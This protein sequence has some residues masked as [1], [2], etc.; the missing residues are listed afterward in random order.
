MPISL[1][2]LLMLAA[3]FLIAGGVGFWLLGGRE[4]KKAASA[5]EVPVVVRLAEKKDVPH[6][7]NAVGTVESLQ[8]VLVRPQVDGVLT[9]ILFKEGDLVAKD[10]LLATIDD[11]S[12]Q[13]VLAAAKA[14]LSSN[15]ALLRA[16]ELDLTRYGGL[17]KQGGVSRQTYEQ[18]RSET[19]RLRAAVEASEARIADAEVQLSYTKIH[20]PVAGRVGIRRVDSG[21]LVRANDTSGLV[22]VTQVDPISVVFTIPQ[23]ELGDL[24]EAQVNAGEE[25]VAVTALDRQSGKELSVGRITAID[26]VVLTGTGTVRVRAVFD[27]AAD[28]LWTGQFVSL[29]VPTT[30][31]RD[32][33]VVPASAVRPGIEGP[34]VYLIDNNLAKPVNVK[35]GYRNDKIAVIADGVDAGA[36]VVTDGYSRLKTDAKVK[37]EAGANDAGVNATGLTPAP[38]PAVAPAAASEPAPVLMMPDAATPANAPAAETKAVAP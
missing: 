29:R 33:I 36:V 18:Q 28:R 1:S 27:N 10:Q 35:L 20:S 17:V 24:R 15:R 4:E 21:N 30:T 37:I 22:M 32:A 5:P 23:D 19:E 26:N 12:Y 8:S 31:T 2:R 11:R 14:E 3:A 7:F 16:A 34:F 13:A 25:G 6:V 9:N 38:V